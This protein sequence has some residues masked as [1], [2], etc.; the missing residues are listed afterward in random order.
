MHG[1]EN[2]GSREFAEKIFDV[3]FEWFCNGA[4]HVSP[5]VE[6][7]LNSVFVNNF[8]EMFNRESRVTE[9][10]SWEIN[11]GFLLVNSEKLGK[12]AREFAVIT[13]ESVLK[14]IIK[15]RTETCD[16]NEISAED[17]RDRGGWCK[18]DVD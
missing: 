4:G 1:K 15:L 2:V 16:K 17:Y 8:I 14:A 7:F 3:C 5:E 6:D 11:Q 13:Q 10:E 18:V 9:Q 12:Y